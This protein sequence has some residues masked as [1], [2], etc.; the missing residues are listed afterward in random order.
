MAAV[1]D[2]ANTRIDRIGHH[3]VGGAGIVSRGINIVG[4][5]IQLIIPNVLNMIFVHLT[6][7]AAARALI[8]TDTQSAFVPVGGILRQFFVIDHFIHLYRHLIAGIGRKAPY[9]N[10]R[11]NVITDHTSQLRI[12]GLIPA[13]ADVRFNVVVVTDQLNVQ[14][15]VV[16]IVFLLNQIFNI[17]SFIH[18]IDLDFK[19]LFL[20]PIDVGLNGC[21]IPIGGNHQKIAVL[22]V[23][24]ILRSFG[25]VHEH[26]TVHRIH[27]R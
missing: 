9:G 18:D 12:H 25:V 19:S 21:R 27:F 22:P 2:D 3:L 13:G 10:I 4:K 16:G 23:I 15:I 5:R 14:Q 6:V 11:V 20:L 1:V 7:V 24:Q 26:R 8:G 17:G